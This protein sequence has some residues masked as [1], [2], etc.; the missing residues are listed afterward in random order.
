MYFWIH[1][2]DCGE[3]S[4]IRSRDTQEQCACS[5]IDWKSCDAMEAGACEECDEINGLHDSEEK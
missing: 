4:E 5:S 2:P 1:C 3:H